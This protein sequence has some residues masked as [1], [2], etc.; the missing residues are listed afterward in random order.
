MFHLNEREQKAKEDHNALNLKRQEAQREYNRVRST[1][2]ADANE[3]DAANKVL[4]A[5]VA[6]LTVLEG[7]DDFLL[8]EM[9]SS[10]NRQIAAAIPG[11]NFG[12]LL[13]LAE[14]ALESLHSPTG[15]RMQNLFK[16]LL[17]EICNMAADR[18]IQNARAQ[19]T[20]SRYDALISTGLP[21]DLVFE[22]IRAEASAPWP[23]FPTGSVKM[24]S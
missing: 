3:I 16:G 17:I 13:S 24:R 7:S 21:K 1:Y 23:S 14:E 22:I 6:E 11:S 20:K 15:Q 9:K 2:M 4:D 8:A 19:I 5:L 10:L 18:D 12:L